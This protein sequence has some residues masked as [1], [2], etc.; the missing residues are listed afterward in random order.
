MRDDEID[1]ILSGE[2]D[3]L[4]SSG[5]HASVMDAVHR[6]ASTLP[7]IPFPWKRAWPGFAVGALALVAALIVLLVESGGTTAPEPSPV[8]AAAFESLLRSA[9]NT[10]S[11]WVALA[12]LVTLASVA[13]TRRLIRA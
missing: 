6:E 10:G 8:G 11:H 1:R 4:P 13:L 2:E 7:P 9:A 12:L 5:F 3:L